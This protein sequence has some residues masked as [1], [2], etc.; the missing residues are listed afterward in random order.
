MD[1]LI[2]TISR[3]MGW[4]SMLE[5]QAK[6]LSSIIEIEMVKGVCKGTRLDVASR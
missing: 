1:G 6:K 2:T 3:L 4:G 5:R